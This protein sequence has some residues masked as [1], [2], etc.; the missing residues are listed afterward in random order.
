VTPAIRISQTK[1][2]CSILDLNAECKR[3]SML[4]NREFYGQ[5]ER[6]ALMKKSVE[7]KCQRNKAVAS[8][9]ALVSL[10]SQLP[11]F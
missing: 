2:V 10:A 5:K 3:S 4:M 8:W 7:K 11:K 9:N 6:Y 1:D